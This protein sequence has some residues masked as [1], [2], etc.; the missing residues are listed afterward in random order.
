MAEHRISLLIKV[1]ARLVI[2]LGFSSCDLADDRKICSYTFRGKTGDST[3]NT[4]PASD[5]QS[6]RTC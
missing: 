2:T 4:S 1:S 3:D 6:F 5:E